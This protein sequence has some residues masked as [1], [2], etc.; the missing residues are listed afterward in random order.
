[1][2]NLKK[3]YTISTADVSRDGP[4]RPTMDSG[5]TYGVIPIGHALAA[6]R[7]HLKGEKRGKNHTDVLSEKE[8]LWEQ[9]ARAFWDGMTWTIQSCH[10]GLKLRLCRNWRVLRLI[11][12]LSLLNTSTPSVG[13]YLIFAYTGYKQL[14]T[15]N[16]SIYKK[17]NKLYK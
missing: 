3:A 15:D 16:V 2:E 13:G 8:M 1:M 14:H 12:T 17:T 6:T 4:S 7:H 10:H 9:L 11:G 5:W